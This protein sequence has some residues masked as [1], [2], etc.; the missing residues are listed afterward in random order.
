MLVF[1]QVC[2]SINSTCRLINWSK[3]ADINHWLLLSFL[4]ENEEVVTFLPETAIDH[5][6]DEDHQVN[7]PLSECFL[8]DVTTEKYN[9]KNME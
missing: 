2:L 6:F 1:E 3:K 5:S 8:L 4:Q 9:C 7:K